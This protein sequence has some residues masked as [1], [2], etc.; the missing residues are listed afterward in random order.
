MR[1]DCHTVPFKFD[2][3]GNSSWSEYSSLLE[4]SVT[5]GTG[6]ARFEALLDRPA[7]MVSPVSSGEV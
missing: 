3:S 7:N 5:S 1:A 6:V 4:I 2:S